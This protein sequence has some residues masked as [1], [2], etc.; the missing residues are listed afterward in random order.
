M[1]S[2]LT[3]VPSIVARGA[4]RQQAYSTRRDRLTGEY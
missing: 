1:S 3:L 2:R 4:T